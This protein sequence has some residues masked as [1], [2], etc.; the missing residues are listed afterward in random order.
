MKRLCTICARGGS[1]GFPNKNIRELDGN[2]II[3]HSIFQAKNSELFELV[4]VNS[5][6]EQILDIAQKWGADYLIERPEE[7]A[8]DD[9]AKLPAIQYGVQFVEKLID[10]KFETIVD[11]DATAPIRTIEDIKGAVNLLETKGISNVIT[12]VIAR[13]SPY[14][15][16]VELN[17]KGR[18]I[19][20]KLL[21]QYII[22][23]QD[24][25]IVYDMNASIY[26]WERSALFKYP[27]TINEETL[28][29]LMNE[30]S[31][32]DIDSELDFEFVEFLLKR[33]EGIQ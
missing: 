29:Y 10:K 8:S 1:K 17:S 28:L 31:S 27:N 4:A 6:S 9:A 16:Q 11:L 3:A 26:V 12:G 18:V 23:R 2:P 14:Y 21:S 7:L 30:E 13:K 25:P 20:P 5:D 19:F 22:R 32:F 15:N 24:A 33:R